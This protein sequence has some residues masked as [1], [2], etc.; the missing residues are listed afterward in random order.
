MPNS[1]APE[2][3]TAGDGETW[4]GNALRFAKREDAEAWVTNLS[5]RWTAV[6]ATRVVESE[7]EPNR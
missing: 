1:F 7:D 3:Q 2:V 4:S 6:K 5:Y